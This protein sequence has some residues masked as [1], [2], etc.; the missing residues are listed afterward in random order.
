M[1]IEY[2]NNYSETLGSLSQYYRDEPALDSN[3]IIIDFTNDNSTDSFK[4]QEK[5]TGQTGNDGT[6]KFEK[7]YHLNM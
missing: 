4:L 6:K 2:S 1:L 5:I 3:G 7:L